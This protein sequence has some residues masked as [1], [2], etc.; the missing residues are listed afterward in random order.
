MNVCLICLGPIEHETADTAYHPRCAKRLFGTA[1]P[2]ETRDIDPVALRE[3]APDLALGAA[4]PGDGPKILVDLS[5][6]G[7]RLRVAP[8]NGRFTLKAQS[9]SYPEWPE[10]ELLTMCLAD[11]AGVE[12]QPCG[13][14]RLTDDSLA[15]LERRFDRLDDGSALRVEDFRRMGGRPIGEQREDSAEASA[16]IARR[17]ASEPLVAL[18]Q[19]YRFLLAAWWT[20]NGDVHLGTLALV[21]GPDNTRRLAPAS[22]LACTRIAIPDDP[23]ALSVGGKTDRLTRADW[24]GFGDSCGLRPRIVERVLDS[25]V[26][27]FDLA[28]ELVSRSFLSENRKVSYAEMVGRRTA[29]LEK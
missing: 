28:L 1:R 4:R 10:N 24:L 22:H 19:L 26:S 6:D 2:P 15:F 27:S 18:L 8:D 11:L 12:V 3:A 13:L 14:I 20:G 21:T 17:Y 7:R 29:R 25:V 23:L 16:E 5:A 9:A